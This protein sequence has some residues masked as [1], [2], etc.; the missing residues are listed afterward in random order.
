MPRTPDEVSASSRFFL[1]LLVLAK[2]RA[3]S[4]S[5]FSSQP[6]RRVDY[7]SEVAPGRERG[8]P[9]Q[10]VTKLTARGESHDVARR[11]QRFHLRP[12]V[13]RFGCGRAPRL[14]LTRS[15]RS[16][17]FTGRV[18]LAGHLRTFLLRRFRARRLSRLGNSPWN[19][20][21]RGWDIRL[22]CE[23]G[24]ELFEL[25]FALV[26][27]SS[28]ELLAIGRSEFLQLRCQC[29]DAAQVKATILEHRQNHGMST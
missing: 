2:R 24:H 21:N 3:S 6:H 25:A 27:G 16:W 13:P 19:L 1:G 9:F 26:D 10:L 29:R 15:G 20:P 7:R 23:L 8:E 12:W 11:S 22:R 18:G 5:S 17:W 14:R 28:Q 4:R